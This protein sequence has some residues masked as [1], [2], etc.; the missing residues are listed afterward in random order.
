MLFLEDVNEHPYRIE[1][2]LLQLQQA[3]VLDAQKAVLL[4]AFSEWRK[5]PLDRGYSLRD[6]DRRICAA[7]RERRS[8][9]ACRSA[10]C[11]PRSACPSARG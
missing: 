5:S 11:R 8:S 1:R 2:S 3:G 7:V 10:T 4:G 6:G 9:P